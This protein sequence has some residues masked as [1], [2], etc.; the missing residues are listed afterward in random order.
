M[1]LVAI[2]MVGIVSLAPAPVWGQVADGPS[3]PATTAEP[4]VEQ[5]LGELSDPVWRKRE[6]AS[7]RLERMGTSIN[8]ELRRAFVQS[9]EYEVR[10]RIKRIAHEA[11]LNE[12]IGPVRAFL[13]IQHDPYDY[14]ATSDPRI[15]PGFTGLRL[16]LVV[17]GS[18]ASMAGLHPGDIVIALN[19]EY[20]TFGNPATGFTR[21][22]GEQLPGTTCTVTVFRGGSGRLLFNNN[23]HRGFDP[24]G[25]AKTERR[26]VRPEEDPRVLPG[27][28]GIVLEDV[29][30]ADP[31]LSL[32]PGDLI[33]GLDGESLSPDSAMSKFGEW[34]EHAAPPPV[35]DGQIG[36]GNIL[37]GPG[38]RPVQTIKPSIQILRGGSVVDF[39]VTLMARPAN[40]NNGR[41]WQR[42][43]VSEERLR[44]A[45]L[46]FEAMWET[47]IGK[48]GPVADVADAEAIWRMDK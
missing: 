11:Y 17:W 47:A 36:P 5:L 45:D 39:Q 4:G 23:E 3:A 48:D 7:A 37:I 31:R 8:D 14:T 19:G 26:L 13:G 28:A 44:D 40:L 42:G 43:N 46:A 22:I 9:P 25:F 41:G 16:T 2:W 24:R 18:A 12:H 30:Q 20:G 29:S 38:G 6:I 33:L 10:S 32:E 21:W 34:C 35:Q 27:L 15:A 1:K